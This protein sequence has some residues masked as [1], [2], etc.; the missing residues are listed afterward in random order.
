MMAIQKP[1]YQRASAQVTVKNQL[2]LHARPAAEFV[3]QA[4][5]FRSDIWVITASGRY[6][7]L[8]LLEVM[9]ANLDCGA[10]ATLEACGPD[11]ERAI[12]HLTKVVQEMKDYED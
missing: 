3:R 1:Q 9:R 4:N 10:I 6:S 2:G 12:A 11:A 8:S 7:A 5:V